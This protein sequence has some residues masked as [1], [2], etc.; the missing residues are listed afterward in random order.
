MS[1]ETFATIGGCENVKTFLGLGAILA[2]AEP[3]RV[4][5][6]LDEIKKGRR[7]SRPDSVI[8]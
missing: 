1:G 5:V 7:I 2:G 8:F 4:V 6:F 3:P